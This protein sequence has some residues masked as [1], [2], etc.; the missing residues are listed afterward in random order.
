MAFIQCDFKSETLGRSCSLNVIL[1]QEALSARP[2]GHRSQTLYLLHGLSDDH[3]TWMRRT[4]IERYAQAF[5]L[6]I[7][8][9][10]VDRSFYANMRSGYRYWDFIADELPEIC[11]R[12][13]PISTEREDVFAA[14]LS[15]GG[16]GAFK[17]ALA[18]PEAVSAAASLSGALDLLAAG[19]EQEERLPEYGIIFG[20]QE[21]FRNSDDDLS[22]LAAQLV[23]SSRPRPSLFQCC[24]TEDYLYP[25]NQSFQ[26]H[27]SRIGLEVAYEQSPGDHDWS[28]WDVQ[29][30]RV[31]AWLPLRPA[32]PEPAI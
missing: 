10:S 16:Y 6:A 18:R 11:R 15:M 25:M 23:A 28:Y 8:M 12:F 21:R 1:N 4:S 2:A 17:L 9:P 26:Q 30:Q 13:F 22:H 7:V 29:I 20:D 14:G 27:C 19:E 3:T 24:G 31:L 32:Q 5:D